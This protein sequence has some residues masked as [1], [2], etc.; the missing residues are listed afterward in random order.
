[1]LVVDG[2]FEEQID[3]LAQYIDSIAEGESKLQEQIEACLQQDDKEA[4]IKAAVDAGSAI[5]NAQEKGMLL[6]SGRGGELTM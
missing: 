5:N 6:I 2:S 1:M 3:E 4:A